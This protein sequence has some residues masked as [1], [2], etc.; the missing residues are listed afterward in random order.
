MIGNEKRNILVNRVIYFYDKNLKAIIYDWVTRR[1]RLT[2]EDA[3]YVRT[4][5]GF[6]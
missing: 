5:R 3:R 4:R 6:Q 1:V 2:K